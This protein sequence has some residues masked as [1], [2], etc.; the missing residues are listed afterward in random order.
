MI[1]DTQIFIKSILLKIINCHIYTL[2]ILGNSVVFIY[3][4]NENH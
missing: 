1:N 2:V 3:R 4:K